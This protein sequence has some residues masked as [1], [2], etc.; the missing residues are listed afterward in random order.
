MQVD[1]IEGVGVDIEK[2]RALASKAGSAY[3]G[4]PFRQ[5]DSITVR[6]DADGSF[7]VVGNDRV[8]MWEGVC[9][10]VRPRG[11]AVFIA[12]TFDDVPELCDAVRALCDE[13]ERLRAEN[14]RL[15]PLVSSRAATDLGDDPVFTFYMP[16]AAKG[17]RHG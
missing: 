7:A 4:Q 8:C 16:T 10:D 2:L 3:E 5:G 17:G 13:V 6:D 12:S 11:L 14:A 15:M 9:D 1:I